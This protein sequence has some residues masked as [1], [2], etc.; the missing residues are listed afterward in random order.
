MQE[1][2]GGYKICW[3]ILVCDYSKSLVYWPV[4]AIFGGKRQLPPI[5]LPKIKFSA[6]IFCRLRIFVSLMML[7]CL[8]NSINSSK[9]EHM[10]RK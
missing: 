9:Y 5:M 7:H 6:A 3:H 4:L 1:I 2:S 8:L 10:I